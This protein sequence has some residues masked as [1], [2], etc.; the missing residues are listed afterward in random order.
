VPG[1]SVTG[2]DKVWR[3]FIFEPILTS[4]ILWGTLKL[5]EVIAGL[6]GPADEQQMDH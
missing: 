6:A 4:K 1:G 2:N 3:K 5:A